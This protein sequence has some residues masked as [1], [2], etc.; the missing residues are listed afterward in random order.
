M[1]RQCVSVVAVAGVA[2]LAASDLNACGDKF[3]RA[4]RSARAK[5]YNAVYP[6]A[7]LIHKPNANPKGMAELES[8][9]KRA[10]H[11]PVSLNDRAAVAD[12]IASAKYDVVI[13]DYADALTLKGQLSGRPGDPGVLP[14]VLKKMNISDKEAARHFHCLLK[15]EEM[16]KVDAL[17]EIDHVMELRRK[18][19]ARAAR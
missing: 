17:T 14:M 10:G 2:V 4:G 11:R 3:L 7:V 1:F 15:V 8:M 9:L 16:T 12:A 18:S 5:G 6:A 19:N 13:A